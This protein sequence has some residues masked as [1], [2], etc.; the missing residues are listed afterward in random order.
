MKISLLVL[1]AL[2]L[3]ACTQGN[4]NENAKDPEPTLINGEQLNKAEWPFT[5]RIQTGGAGCSATVIGP[6]VVI[7]AAHCGANGATST[8][9][10][11]SKTYKGKV[12]RSALYP[13]QDHDI[14]VILVDGTI[15]KEDVKVFAKVSNKIPAI[16]DKFYLAGYG[17][18]RPG[19]GG[20]NDGILRG[21]LATVTGFSGY[22]IV[23]GKRGE[24]ALCFG[25]SGG[26][27]YV[28]KS[29]EAPEIIGVN[30]K[31][32]IRDT[33]YN[34]NLASQASKQFFAKLIEQHSVE[35][36]GINGTEKTC[37]DE[38][39]P[40]PPPP[41]PP[42]GCDEAKKKELLSDLAM[43]LDVK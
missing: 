40:P 14:A 28:E 15:A 6:K 2:F 37:G 12:L 38:E 30:S 8:F 24:A 18:I 19:G 43:C 32:N 11:G 42:A 13:N 3:N 33:N 16:G 22:D 21:G 41:P 10:V 5:V 27:M 35:I 7:T 9:K 39:N 29:T 34:T 23:S 17:C 26:P 25:D 36:C 4:A 1:F 31:G 20:G